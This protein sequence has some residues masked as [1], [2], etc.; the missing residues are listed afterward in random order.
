M[1]KF[2][3]FP[4]AVP[5]AI[6]AAGLAQASLAQEQATPEEVI[7][8][9]NQA[10][11]YLS[12]VGEAGLEKFQSRD[13]EYV[14]KDTYVNVAN[15]ETEQ[16]AA[17]PIRPELAGSSFA[18]APDFGDLTSEELGEMF[19]E[20]GH[21]PEGGWTEYDFPKPGESAPSRKLSYSKAAE[22]T[23]FVAIGGIYS[24]DAKIEELEQLIRE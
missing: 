3:L 7:R 24:D 20:R 23:P 22:G 11:E 2:K 1:L 5:F 15:C 21:R 6:C 10:A 16:L 12:E 13:S 18:D 14:W 17:H 4:T 9:V 8:K 19:C